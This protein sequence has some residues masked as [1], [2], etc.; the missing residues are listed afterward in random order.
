MKHT[1]V[2]AAIAAGLLGV[3][4]AAHAVPT[5]SLKFDSGAAFV[6]ADG[7]TSCDT[8]PLAGIVSVSTT[9]GESLVTLT[10][11]AS[12]PALTGGNPLMDLFS[13]N[14]Q[15]WGDPHTLVIKLSDTGFDLYGGRISLEH[16]GTLSGGT[17]AS[18]AHSAYYDAGDAL[19][20]EST[21][22]GA[23]GPYGPGAFSGTVD[24]GVSPNS[25]YSVTEILTLKTAGGLTVFSG[26]FEVNVPEPT[27]LALLGIGL[28]GFAAVRRRRQSS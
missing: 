2:H 19:F 6:C 27:T 28:I 9:F 3:V 8:N 4:P 10:A 21:L 24:G 12:K 20:A 7:N 13:F 17:G 1:L 22:I 23:V 25:S 18:I 15:L 5:L 11:G 16:G 14:L 26:D